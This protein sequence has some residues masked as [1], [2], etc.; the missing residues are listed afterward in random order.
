MQTRITLAGESAGAVHV[1]AH[2][3][4]KAPVQ[5]AFMASGSLYLSPP[6]P[7]EVG[8]KLI[9]RLTESLRQ[10]HGL[11]LKDA[12]ASLLVKNLSELGVN[13]IWLQSESSLDGWQIREEEIMSL[14]IGD[15]E[16]EVCCPRREARSS[17]TNSVA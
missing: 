12:P 13:S 14:M 10:S 4:T 2:I 16:C 1:H 7:P 5:Q 6:Q 15:V 11:S 9:A 17:I 8:Q 3:L